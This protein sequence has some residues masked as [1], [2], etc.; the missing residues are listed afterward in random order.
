M[1]VCGLD[2]HSVVATST[3]GEAPLL[4]ELVLSVKL[5]ETLFSLLDLSLAVIKPWRTT[6][7]IELTLLL[8]MD[9]LVSV[10][11]IRGDLDILEDVVKGLTH[12]V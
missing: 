7:H 12:H 4:Q 5:F 6:W 2:E 1:L 8:E 9:L 10:Q 11:W 3:N